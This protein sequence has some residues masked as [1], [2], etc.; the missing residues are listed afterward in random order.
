MYRVSSQKFFNL[1]I[2][3]AAVIGTPF[4]ARADNLDDARNITDRAMTDYYDAL[5]RRGKVT[6][7]S[8]RDLYDAV[9]KPRALEAHEKRTGWLKPYLSSAGVETYSHEE[10]FKKFGVKASSIP[11]VSKLPIEPDAPGEVV[12]EEE[13]VEVKPKGIAATLTGAIDG[14]IRAIKSVISDDNKPKVVLDSKGVPEKIVFGSEGNRNRAP[15]DAQKGNSKVWYTDGTSGAA[16][17]QKG[18]D[19]QMIP[20]EIHFGK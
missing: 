18:G 9:V 6:P 3:V 10:Y 8:R 5:K 13:E 15:A 12:A 16:D 14:T 19:G 2:L 17:P 7:T 1:W 4:G 20:N 11:D